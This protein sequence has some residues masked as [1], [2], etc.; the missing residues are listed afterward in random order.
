MFVFKGGS[1]TGV[2]GF[3][4]A[5]VGGRRSAGEKLGEN[6]DGSGEGATIGVSAGVDGVCRRGAELPEGTLKV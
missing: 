1:E 5:G 4:R 2:V 3:D 6:C